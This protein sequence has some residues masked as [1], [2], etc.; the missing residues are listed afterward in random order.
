VAHGVKEVK[1][2]GSA[3]VRTI[4]DSEWRAIKVEGQG[5]STW[6]KSNKFTIPGGQFVDG[7]IDYFR[8]DSEFEVVQEQSTA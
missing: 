3:D 8:R 2:K 5:T 4:F 7:A 6:D 1:Y